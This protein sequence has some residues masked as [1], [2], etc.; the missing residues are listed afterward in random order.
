MGLSASCVGRTES[1]DAL[2]AKRL[3]ATWT[4]TPRKASAARF[5][6]AP[7]AL[8]AAQALVSTPTRVL[9][10]ATA[11]PPSPIAD[12]EP[13][14]ERALLQQSPRALPLLLRPTPTHAAFQRID[15]RGPVALPTIAPMALGRGREPARLIIPALN[16][17]APVVPVGWDEAYVGRELMSEWQ[18]ASHAVGHHINS[19]YPGEDGNMVFSGHN[20][21]EGAVFRSLSRVGE[22]GVNFG[23]GAEMIVEDASGRQFIYRVNGWERMPERDASPEQRRYNARYLAP[24]ERAQ[25]TIITCWPPSS[26][27]HRVVVTGLLTGMKER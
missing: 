25:L 6:P 12:S 22:P 23:L 9:A 26:N 18:V 24:T 15:R 19:V 10:A 4:P 27:T 11:A 21:I 7:P 16:L 8:T 13:R 14:E 17:N 20:N 5:T 1:V 2:P 3:V